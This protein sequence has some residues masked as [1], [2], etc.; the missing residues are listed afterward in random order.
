MR[1]FLL[2]ILTMIAIGNNTLFAQQGHGTAIAFHLL[3]SNS[4]LRLDEKVNVPD[5]ED[6][7]SI[8]TLRFYISSIEFM[9]GNNSIW[10]EENS[11][12]LVDASDARSL[13]MRLNPPPGLSFNRVKFN[14]GIDSTTNVSGVM[15][16]ALDPTHGMYWTWQ[17]GYINLKL[18]G[19]SNR[20]NKRNNEFVYHLGG[21]QGANNALQTVILNVKSKENINISF[22]AG[23]FLSMI[24][25]S[26]V[27]HIMS[28]GKDAVLLAARIS[29][30]FTADPQ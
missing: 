16:D 28:P 8:E 30:L 17:S 26:T 18:E 25:I 29:K 1:G 23:S 19:K 4:P 12:H 20:C 10:K 11:Y 21:Y 27:N 3:F 7:I 6:T 15:G 24:D 13:I 22:D 5:R 9:E 2:V 14:L